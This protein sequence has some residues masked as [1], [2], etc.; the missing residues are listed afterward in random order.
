[1]EMEGAAAF[2]LFRTRHAGSMS[3]ALIPQ[4]ICQNYRYFLCCGD[5]LHIHTPHSC[6]IVHKQGHDL[7]IQGQKNVLLN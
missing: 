4:A 5:T 3:V 6:L 1:M 2:V 7:N